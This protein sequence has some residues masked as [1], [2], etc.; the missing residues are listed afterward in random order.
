MSEL[1]K[2]ELIELSND[3]DPK[4][5]STVPVQ[6]NPNSLK[7]KLSNKSEGG[8]SKGRQRRQHTGV[9]STTLSMDLVFDASDEGTTSTPVSVRTKTAIVEKFVV[10]QQ[11]KSTPPKIRFRWGDLQ[12]DGVVSDLSLD[13]DH[14]SPGGIPLRAK[15]SLSLTEQDARYEMLETGTGSKTDNSAPKPTAGGSDNAATPGSSAAPATSQSAAALANETPP[16]FAARMGL[17]PQAWRGLDVDLGTG[18]SLEGGTEV[19]FRSDLSLSSGVGLSRGHEAGLNVSLD[20]SLGLDTATPP[21]KQLE[22]GKVL[23]A[24][25]GVAAAIESVKST[26]AAAAAQAARE[27]FEPTAMMT[28]ANPAGNSSDPQSTPSDTAGAVGSRITDSFRQTHSDSAQGTVTSRSSQ[29]DSAS[30]IARQANPGA[31]TFGLGIPM[32]PRHGSGDST[33]PPVIG[34]NSAS[35][36]ASVQM[37]RD[38]SVPAWQ[39]LPS[40]NA[41]HSQTGQDCRKPTAKTCGCRNHCHCPH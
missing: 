24:A 23:A 30:V 3:K 41:G 32:R 8:Q 21:S 31:T 2:A 16:E 35:T 6:F 10:T 14:F 12:I 18:L 17:D 28:T 37:T 40:G 11:G 4:E 22:Q 13:F 7:L 29:A 26:E 15:C 9:N 20:T 36:S 25:G 38:P 5:L 27:A 39:Q 34:A 1:K 19:G 33:R